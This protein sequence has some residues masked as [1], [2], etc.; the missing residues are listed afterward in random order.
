MAIQPALCLVAL[1]KP[2]LILL[3]DKNDYYYAIEIFRK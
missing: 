1:T 2:I 3:I